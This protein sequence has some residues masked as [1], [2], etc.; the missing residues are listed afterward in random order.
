MVLAMV[1]IFLSVLSVVAL[2][3]VRDAV[4]GEQVS[5]NIH[6]NAVA[7]QSA[8]TAMRLCEDAVRTG[9]A[10]L[11]S[12]SVV[13]N[14]ASEG[15]AGGDM[16]TQWK[17]RANWYAGAAKVT[18]IPADY[19]TTASMRPLP[20]PRCMIEQYRLRRPDGDATLSDP[21]LITAVGYSPDYLANANGNAVAGS[22][23]WLQSVLRP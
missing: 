11:G 8:E 12:A 20:R 15:L 18:L 17:T 1:L 10:M 23:V 16:P 2:Y 22:E 4:T 3:T 5:K 6:T 9:Q 7:M 21:Y 14:D 13:K 19:I